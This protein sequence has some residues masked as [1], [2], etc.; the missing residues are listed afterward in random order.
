MKNEFRASLFR[1]KP[2]KLD[3]WKAWCEKLQTTLYSQAIETLT[4]EKLRQEVAIL[5]TIDDEYYVVGC[6]EGK[7][8]VAP[9]AARDI[10][11]E[12]QRHK[13]ECLDKVS[14]ADILYNL[15]SEE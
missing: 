13:S 12:H 3:Q 15:E 9:N 4:E 7:N 14:Q 10:N 11:R 6:M 2:G 8:Y 5:L 1:V